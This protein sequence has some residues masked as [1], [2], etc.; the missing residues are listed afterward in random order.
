V[1][2][3]RK[4]PIDLWHRDSLSFGTCGR[5]QRWVNILG[6]VE[7]DRRRASLAYS[8]NKGAWQPLSIG[9]DGFRLANLGDFNIEL[10]SRALPP[11]RNQLRIRAEFD[12]GDSFTETLFFQVAESGQ[13]PSSIDLDFSKHRSLPA[14]VDVVDGKWRSTREG[15]RTDQPYYDRCLAFADSTW[16]D[17]EV[18]ATVKYHGARW[19]NAPEDAGANVVHAA[20]ATRWPGHH[21]DGRQPRQK[22]HPLGATAEFRVNPSWQNCSWRVIGDPAQIV[23][24][25][26]DRSI[27]LEKW[28]CLKHRVETLDPAT[29]LYSARIWQENE[30]EPSDWDIQLSKS[31]QESPSGGFLLIAHYS[32][33]T[34][35]SLE[36]KRLLLSS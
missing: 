23:E 20:I 22:W 18:T 29:A 3:L 1:P 13:A 25:S 17:Y 2:T 12:R 10:D 33:L 32:D 15:L 11:G 34:F 16:T 5:P 4:G 14:Q 35:G 19:P 24:A 21:D 36:A 27:D 31:N 30:P 28:Y 7:C 26:K 9:P 6:C 8:L